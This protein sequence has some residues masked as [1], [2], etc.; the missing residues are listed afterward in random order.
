MAYDPVDGAIVL[1]GCGEGC[2]TANE[3]WELYSGQWWQVHAPNPTPSYQYGYRYG[4]ALTYDSALSKIVL[5]GGY[6][7]TGV[8]N[9]T[10]TFSN[11]V[12]T[13]VTGLVG[14]A[15]PARRSAAMSVDS[16]G[17]PPLLFGGTQTSFAAGNLN[18]TWVLESP[19]TVALA[20][21]PVTTATTANVT[22][23]ASVTNGTPPYRAVFEFGE[24]ATAVATS[25]TTSIA[26]THAYLRAGT[27]RPSVN[28]TDAAGARS[29]S[30]G[31]PG[32]RVIAGP[33]LAP[34]TEPSQGDVGIPLSFSD[35]NLTNGTSPYVLA[36]RFGDGDTASGVGP[37]HSYAAAGTYEGTLTASDALGGTASRPFTVVVHP[38]PVVTVSSEPGTPTAGTPSTLF[39]NLSGGTAPYRYAWTF[40]DGGTSTF[41]FPAHNFSAAGSYAVQVWVNDS[42]G[43][44]AHGSMTVTVAGPS[45]APLGRPVGAPVW[46]WGGVIGLVAVGA[47]GA[48]LLLRRRS[49]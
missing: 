12:W 1:F 41:P 27:Y 23:T 33:A 31:L 34:L 46:F 25:G 18:D 42:V 49:G 32:V 19:P 37:S 24:G 26:V 16:S 10:W 47:L 7:F 28:L 4:D 6:S 44:S 40:G 9:D 38:L 3:T 29:P 17:F 43:G 48:V 5:F 20:A 11:G 2:G 45:S 36:W 8:L 30:V 13:N 21:A 35:G 22:V 39:A 15:P 14:P